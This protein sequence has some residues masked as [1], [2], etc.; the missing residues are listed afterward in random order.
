MVNM[1]LMNQT[2]TF[3]GVD[4]TQNDYKQFTIN[5][6]LPEEYSFSGW[7]KWTNIPTQ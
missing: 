4:P 3:K 2:A 5:A 7:Y 6:N 1:L